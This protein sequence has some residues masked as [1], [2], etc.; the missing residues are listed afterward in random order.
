VEAKLSHEKD[1]YIVHVGGTLDIEDTQGFKSV[2]L[3][4]LRK[5]KIIFNIQ[6]ASFVGSTG[7]GPFLETLREVST[8]GVCGLKM[9]GAS[10]EFKRLLQNLELSN[11]EIFETNEGA[12]RSFT[13][14]V[15]PQVILTEPSILAE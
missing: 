7:L 2:V 14:P 1:V 8:Q 13:E 9:V 10:S 15:M 5:Q 3:Q 6:K 12:L 11:L 4:K